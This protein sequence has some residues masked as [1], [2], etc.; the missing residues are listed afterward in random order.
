MAL[1]GFD[2]QLVKNSIG[3]VKNAY[4][5]LINQIG[6]NMQNKFVNGMQDKWACKEAQEFFKIAFK[7]TVDE[8]NKKTDATF[9]SVVEAMD[10]AAINWAKQTKSDYSKAGFTPKNVKMNVDVIKENIKGV[11][12]VD[13]ASANG[14]ADKLKDIA[15]GATTALDQAKTAVTNCGFVGGN[16]Q[17]SLVSSLNKIKT[18][19]NEAVQ[20]I[21]TDVNK[22]IKN[23]VSV[24]SD[25]E[26]KVSAAFQGK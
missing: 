16:Q 12:G 26:G 17:E 13:G 6:T 5:A 24:Y 8:L 10:S 3:K 20:T 22:A 14:V 18:S 1:T 25:L 4:D 2:P 7:P 21:T 19:I 23:T 9:K 15:S 11:R